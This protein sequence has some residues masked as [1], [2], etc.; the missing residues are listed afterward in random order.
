M[1]L[2]DSGFTLRCVEWWL[3]VFETLTGYKHADFSQ[4]RS[5]DVTLKCIDHIRT[6]FPAAKVS[7]E[8]EKPGRIGLQ[9][10]AGAADVVM[11]SKGWAQVMFLSF[12]FLCK[13]I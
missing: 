8:V 3:G 9:E 7:V 2:V 4:G 13:N 1:R 5:P 12:L 10:L 6:Q 11:Y